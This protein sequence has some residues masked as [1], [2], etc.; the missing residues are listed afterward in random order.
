[1][2]QFAGSIV[3]RIPSFRRGFNRWFYQFLAG[4]DRD[5]EVTLMNYGYIPPSDTKPISLSPSDE[6]NRL[7]LQLYHHVASGFDLKGHSVLEVGS[8][9]GGGAVYVNKTFNPAT[10]TGVDYSE[11]AVAFCQHTHRDAGLN[12]VHGDAES[13]PFEDNRFEAA[14]NVE[15][16]HCYGSMRRFLSEVYRVLKPGGHLLWAD[17]R[18]ADDEAHVDHDIREVGFN[19]R[20]AAAITD[21]VVASMT[22]Q[23]ERYR[24]LIERKVPRFA[25]GIFNQYAGVDG[26]LIFHRMKT[27]DMVYLHRVLSKPA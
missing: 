18:S 7:C 15:S 6:P 5:G 21:N 12:F 13:L 19:V 23:G 24:S 3:N 26:S 22:Q 4:I 20:H 27:G 2:F 16:S 10:M 11:R 1:M 8:G 14:L 25:Q 17:F 9:R